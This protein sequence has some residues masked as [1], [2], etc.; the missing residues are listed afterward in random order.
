MS[1]VSLNVTFDSSLG[2]KSSDL[3]P[4]GGSV[5]GLS[6]SFSKSNLIA[7]TEF[8]PSVSFPAL[9]AFDNCKGGGSP[10]L[11]IVLIVVGVSICICLSI[12]CSIIGFF[13]RAL[14]PWT[15]GGGYGFIGGSNHSYGTHHHHHNNGGGYYSG[16]G[17]RSSGLTGS[18]GFAN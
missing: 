12:V 3:S 2:L 6:V 4:V 8:A 13:R 5:N 17:G 1:S 18:S 7:N 14:F 15:R 10:I 16:G 11:T 9:S